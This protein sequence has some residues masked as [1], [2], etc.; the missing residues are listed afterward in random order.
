MDEN[1]LNKLQSSVLINVARG[2]LVSEED[3][4][5]ALKSGGLQGFGSDVWY[6]YPNKNQKT[7]MPSKYPMEAFENVVMTPHCGGFEE[8]SLALRCQDVVNQI[9]EYSKSYLI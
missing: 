7:I 6:Q 1:I 9:I 3:L 4:Y 2:P 8:T 5:Q